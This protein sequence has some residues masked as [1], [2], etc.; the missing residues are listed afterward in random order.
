MLQAIDTRTAPLALD[1][2]SRGLAKRSRA[3]WADCLERLARFGGNAAANLPLGYLL[4]SGAAPVG[5]V[6]TP[7]SVRTGADGSQRRMINISSW[8]VE[9]QHRWRAPLMM[10]AVLRESNATF[11]DLTPTERV[12]QTLQAMGFTPVNAG[13]RIVPLLQAAVRRTRGAQVQDLQAVPRD[14]ISAATLGLLE[15]HRQFGCI[16]LALW[17]ESAWH[18]LMFKPCTLRGIPAVRLIYCESSALLVRHLASVARRLLAEKK[19]LLTCDMPADGSGH[20]FARHG[21]ALKFIKGESWQDR[22][23]YAGSELALF[24]L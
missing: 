18:P 4:L 24:D 13:E 15:S 11:T 9:A 19:L 2:L 17:A 14:A 5:I 3:F 12:Q 7:A 23:D 20:G 8:Y 22:I 16:P 21:H 1:I 10:R 6:L